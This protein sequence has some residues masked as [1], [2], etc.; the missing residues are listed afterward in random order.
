VLRQLARLGRAVPFAGPHALAIAV[1]SDGENR[2][3]RAQQAGYEGVACVDDAAR[4]LEL[5]CDIWKAT[6]APWALRWCEGLLDFILA[7]QDS[8]GRW[9]NF[10]LDW[11]GAPNHEARTS[12]AGGDFWQARALLA[13]ARAAQL[14][15]NGRI[16]DALQ[17]GLPHVVEAAGVP[18][19]VRALHIRTALTLLETRDDRRLRTTLGAWTDAVAGCRDGD[20]LMNS[21]A[22]RG[23]PHL[24]AHIQEGVL[25]DAGVRLGR[26]DLVA[27]GC[28]SA[29]LVFRRVVMSGFDLPRT[30]PYDV[31]SAVYVLARIAD[32]T[33]A[34]RYAALAGMA[35]S[36]FDGRNRA[37]QPVYDR[38]AGRVGDGVE[39]GRVSSNSGAEANIV[40]AQALL[41]DTTT[42]ARRLTGLE[43][44]PAGLG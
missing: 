23:A 30:Q 16:G 17:R 31:A 2:P 15:D 9:L 7:M 21:P 28:R 34:P 20:V 39:D 40:G 12:V 4:A 29:E 33:G 24:W 19:D 41:D 6:A 5:Y 8:D 11:D 1:Y 13:L 37:G 38:S 42:L 22:E 10:I 36:W 26:E 27:I 44:L 32:V 43:A 3:I 35:R 18:S 25:V 14:I